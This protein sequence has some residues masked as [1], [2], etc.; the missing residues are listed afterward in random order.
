MKQSLK[1]VGM[2]KRLYHWPWC[3]VQVRGQGDISML[4]KNGKT[5]IFITCG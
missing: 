3:F 4:A 5:E 1:K 2:G